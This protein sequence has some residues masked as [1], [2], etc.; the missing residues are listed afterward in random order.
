MEN[1]M[2]RK[3]VGQLLMEN[4]QRVAEAAKAMEAENP[5]NVAYLAGRM[6]GLAD[7]LHVQRIAENKTA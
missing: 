1:V 7:A 6:D 4:M 3:N 5:L 2:I